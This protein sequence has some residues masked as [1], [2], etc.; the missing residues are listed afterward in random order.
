MAQEN[1]IKTR[2]EEIADINPLQTAASEELGG[3]V[4][5]NAVL[6]YDTLQP[7]TQPPIE[8]FDA[9]T[10]KGKGIENLDFALDKVNSNAWGLFEEADK[11]GQL[12]MAF[13]VE[14]RGSKT[15]ADVIY[16]IDYSELR[17]A[18]IT[19]VEKLTAY[20]RR[21]HLA[22]A[23]L[24]N[25]VG[26]YMTV[27]QIYHSMGY[28]NR[29]NKRDIDKIYTSLRKMRYLKISLDNASEHDAFTTNKNGKRES[30]REYFKYDGVLLPWE[31]VRK[32]VNGHLAEAVIHPF[33]EPPL[34]AFARGRNQVTKIS[35]NLLA[36]PLSMT[37]KN[38]RITDYL[39]E[40]ISH[41]KRGNL[42]NKILYSTIFE[43]AEITAKKQKSRAKDD[44]DKILEHWKSINYIQGFERA[45]DGVIIYV[46]P[47]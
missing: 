36:V 29:P 20:D 32:E 46:Q 13:A 19:T 7:Q 9:L 44:I 33:R 2:L 39:I 15:P 21:V 1:I 25:Y 18:G 43:K 17:E 6:T 41:A 5:G 40:R 14:K 4:K 3:L 10:V 31:A 26:E 8:L 12:T 34:M 47:L 42:S 24:F 11:N 27:S 30:T 22:V 37:E 35:R 28:N 23:N 38:L 16:S 45:K